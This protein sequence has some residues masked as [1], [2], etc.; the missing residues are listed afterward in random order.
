M[1]RNNKQ[2]SSQSFS[3]KKWKRIRK[4]QSSR[5]IRQQ[6]SDVTPSSSVTP[7]SQIGL[8]QSQHHYLNNNNPKNNRILTGTLGIMQIYGIPTGSSNDLYQ[9]NG[10]ANTVYLKSDLS[11]NQFN[12]DISNLNQMINEIE[13]FNNENEN[14]GINSNDN[15]EIH[16][17]D[18]TNSISITDHSLHINLANR[19][20][21][22]NLIVKH[23]EDFQRVKYFDI[24]FLDLSDNDM[25]YLP[26]I[27]QQTNNIKAIS[28]KGNEFK[29]FQ[30]EDS[31][32][33]LIELNLSSNKL[34]EFLRCEDIKKL[35]FLVKL[36]LNNNQIQSISDEMIEAFYHPQ[37]AYNDINSNNTDNNNTKRK[38]K[39]NHYF[40]GLDKQDRI[41]RLQVLDLSYNQLSIHLPSNIGILT[42]L[43]SLDLSN[44]SLEI[45]PESITNLNLLYQKTSSL[46]TIQPQKLNIKDNK[47]I[48]PPQEIAER[49]GLI[50]I[51]EHFRMVKLNK[52][53]STVAMI[54][55][56]NDHNNEIDMNMNQLYYSRHIR[57]NIVGHQGAGKSEIVKEFAHINQ[58]TRSMSSSDDEDANNNN[59]NNN[60]V[61]QN[62]I[63]SH[64]VSEDGTLSLPS[65]FSID[66][67]ILRTVGYVFEDET[68]KTSL[69]NNNS[70]NNDNIHNDHYH[71]S[72]FKDIIVN[73]DIDQAVQQHILATL[74]P[75]YNS[76]SNI[77]NN[78]DPELLALKS[79][80]FEN[81]KNALVHLA[82]VGEVIWFQSNH[83]KYD[84]ENHDNYA[85]G[86]E[87]LDVKG[88]TNEDLQDYNSYDDDD[89]FYLSNVPSRI[90]SNPTSTTNYDDYRLK[91]TNSTNSKHSSNSNNSNNNNS[92][93]N[94]ND[95]N[96]YNNNNN[97]DILE[98]DM[99]D[100]NN[101]NLD[102]LESDEEDEEEENENIYFNYFML[103][104]IIFLSP[105]WLKK[106][107]KGVMRNDMN[108]VLDL[109]KST[110]ISNDIPTHHHTHQ[111]DD[112]TSIKSLNDENL[113]LNN[114]MNYNYSNGVVPWDLIEILLS[115]YSND[116]QEL[117][118]S[119]NDL[120]KETLYILR[121]VLIYFNILIPIADDNE[122]YGLI[123]HP[124]YALRHYSDN[125]LINNNNNNNNPT[126]D[127]MNNHNIISK[128][129]IIQSQIPILGT[130]LYVLPTI[131]PE[132]LDKHSQ[133]HA[134]FAQANGIRLER[135]LKYTRFVPSGI[136]PR[137]I[138]RMHSKHGYILKSSSQLQS[139]SNSNKC[140]R[141]M[142]IQEYGDCTVWVMAG[143]FD[144]LMY[145]MDD[146][147]NNNSNNNRN[148]NNNNNNNKTQKKSFQLRIIS[149][150]FIFDIQSVIES[151]DI[152]CS[153]INDIMDEYRGISQLATVTLCPI[154][155][156]KQ[157]SE[158]KY[159][160]NFNRLQGS[161]VSYIKNYLMP[162]SL[163]S[164]NNH[165]N[166][167]QTENNHR[168]KMIKSM[169]RVV[170]INVIFSSDM[171][172]S[173]CI[174]EIRN[175]LIIC[176]TR[177]Q[178]SYNDLKS[179]KIDNNNINN[180]NKLKG[181][182]LTA[183][184]PSRNE[185][186]K[187]N[188]SY[189]FLVGD[190]KHWKYIAQYVG[191]A[192]PLSN[193]SLSD[194]CLLKLKM[195][196]KPINIISIYKSMS[197][198]TSDNNVYENNNNNNS[199]YKNNI[200][201][202]NCNNK[203]DNNIIITIMGSYSEDDTNVAYL[204]MYDRS[205]CHDFVIEQ[206]VQVWGYNRIHNSFSLISLY[207]ENNL[208]GGAVIDCRGTIVGVLSR[209]PYKKGRHA[210]YL[211]AQL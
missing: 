116:L 31:L 67:D 131:L 22:D 162:S 48:N 123:S 153:V 109:K 47:L 74:Y 1:N 137:I 53:L 95:N 99:E 41:C 85:N 28:L 102:E 62:K 16:N 115:E 33:A 168:N 76:N 143:Y 128:Y 154:C 101:S 161:I 44:N 57:M 198:S 68:N 149:Y 155:L 11:F 138:A 134:P 89:Q 42:S 167:S 69:N 64:Q 63:L 114:I 148:N 43:T 163:L 106:S 98:E 144:N 182:I 202:N 147:D 66:K 19:N 189:Y 141:T 187:V 35:P 183:F 50:S 8:F 52:I 79:N 46:A 192:Y 152:Y 55:E 40:S 126:E 87:E 176:G 130:S 145:D 65:Y 122:D 156:M 25:T 26:K 184:S 146:Y 37:I 191:P 111:N 71:S 103:N 21:T 150:G 6:F 136:I 73:I 157:Y 107:L 142:F 29:T 32:T 178:L 81:T 45:L 125:K 2:T 159:H 200:D 139:S 36:Y 78:Q 127:S 14:S 96:N 49:N 133:K 108:T 12:K 58:I 124:N 181:F 94:N 100:D 88:Y 117:K 164:N 18:Q 39:S 83:Q 77:N 186:P 205:H 203:I 4:N 195:I 105:N 3:S 166:N 5:K 172:S 72:S 9:T 177:V 82:L 118:I 27:I 180:N 211:V 23:I 185:Q 207:S 190:A 171:I 158:E 209:Y 80:S 56:N 13:S 121:E 120:Y 132:A 59:N 92:I 169:V 54:Q 17:N 15:N 170:P 91:Q 194:A 140:W 193:P 179:L 151:L 206:I 160:H 93:S 70:N 97:I 129:P 84:K 30:L 112:L 20:L 7:L 208:I 34:R 173:V 24:I 174:N 61:P 104:K 210:A 10:G 119:N 90:N 197:S 196:I 165:N 38:N 113:P 51:D 60:N 199:S 110:L 135:R 175:E 188:S 201:N 86:D 204:E 75:N